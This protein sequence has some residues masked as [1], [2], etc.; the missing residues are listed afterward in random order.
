M[1]PMRPQSHPQHVLDALTAHTAVVA[2]DGEI[3]S[4]NHAWKRF[5]DEN[6]LASR[7]YCVGDSYHEACLSAARTDPVA[8]GVCDAIRG[9]CAGDL[10]RAEF[11]YPCH[12]RDERRWFVVHISPM[13]VRADRFALVL[14]EN[15][16]RIKTAEE[17]LASVADLL[18]VPSG[19]GCLWA[20][21]E[22]LRRTLPADCVLVTEV[23]HTGEGRVRV[24]ASAGGN[25]PGAGLIV[26]LSGTP[27]ARLTGGSRSI[28]VPSGAA[29]SFAVDPRLA[30]ARGFIG[31]GA[32]EDELG[33]PLGMVGA[34]WRQPVAGVDLG[35][36]VVGL[37]AG[38]VGE[39]LQRRRAEAERDRTRE[40][41]AR[42]EALDRRAVE[43]AHEL[44]NLLFASRAQ[45]SEASKA[46][47]E[48]RSPRRAHAILG[49]LARQAV[50][51]TDSLR[52][53]ASEPE[54]ARRVLW[55]A[56]LAREAVATVTPLLPPEMSVTLDADERVRVLGDADQLKRALVNLTLN[57][58]NAM[59]AGEGRIVVGAHA[60][61]AEAVLS[62]TDTGEGVSGP[63]RDRMFE[64]RFTTR[65]SEGGEGLGLT[66]VDEIARAHAGRVAVRTERGVGTTISIVLPALETGAEGSAN[67][68]AETGRLALVVESDPRV[69]EVLAG[70]LGSMGYSVFPRRGDEGF[71][72]GC[73]P[74]PAGVTLVVAESGPPGGDGES[75]LRGLREIG[76]KGP[77]VLMSESFAGGASADATLGAALLAKPFSETEL[78][79]AIGLAMD[80]L[81][82]AAP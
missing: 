3:V 56:D 22:G 11:E 20:I 42:T 38:R 23:S 32:G 65:R 14:H 60:Q 78:R 68:D 28:C 61:G 25:S 63:V 4:V 76:Y 79:S 52:D 47:D 73:E 57:A 45:L 62:V 26:A 33:R 43:T 19:E 49:E 34:L 35:R 70:A 59:R 48:G 18:A 82:G 27:E 64:R 6:G 40:L 81:R 5:A 44:K 17:S 8:A 29:E 77:A 12:S 72:E 69:R 16:T 13:R 54:T 74:L 55:L 7:D 31:A 51:L 41:A 71:D 24:L 36:R 37:S 66:V 21:A 30:G 9:V 1:R 53:L 80:L 39:E 46:V 15:V 10:T 58:R 67:A 50:L 75:L 2:Q